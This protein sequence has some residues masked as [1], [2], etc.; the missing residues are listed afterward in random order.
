MPVVLLK[1]KKYL[2]FGARLAFQSSPLKENSWTEKKIKG[3]VLYDPDQ[4]TEEGSP[5]LLTSNPGPS[6]QSNGG[7]V[8][9]PRW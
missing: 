8:A 4:I 3:I 9:F 1:K 6:P 7:R 5:G 2:T